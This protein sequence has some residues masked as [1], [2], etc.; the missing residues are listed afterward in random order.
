MIGCVSLQLGG[1][2]SM[3]ESDFQD[4][5]LK[6]LR[7]SMDGYSVDKGD[8]SKVIKLLCPDQKTIELGLSNLYRQ[9]LL[10]PYG[11]EDLRIELLRR[12]TGLRGDSSNLA[13]LP[14]N[15]VEQRIFPQLNQV[16][17]LQELELI[18]QPFDEDVITTL[19]VD[20]DD[21]YQYVTREH[22]NEWGVTEDEIMETAI[23]NL[24]HS[25]EDIEIQFYDGD[26][27]FVLVCGED[28]YNA[29]R[30]LLPSMKD[31]ASERLGTPFF[32]AIPN[33]NFLAMW[34]VWN[35]DEYHEHMQDEVINSFT[36]ELH[37]LTPKVYKLE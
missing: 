30:I 3:N 29:A 2:K 27:K 32:A 17:Q 28:G 21:H 20:F 34:S 16:D 15:E 19:V 22:M 35:K 13:A 26:E 24:H 10:D 7:G 23:I 5:V 18:C 1:G 9:H 36:T 6:I 31:I 11:E 14:W 25:T 37:P 33:R 8:G 12:I 4:K